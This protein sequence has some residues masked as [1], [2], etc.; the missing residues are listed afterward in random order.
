MTYKGQKRNFVID[1]DC[2]AEKL[3]SK[4]WIISD[5]LGAGGVGEV[6]ALCHKQHKCSRVI[7]IES[8]HNGTGIFH[9]EVSMLEQAH[10]YGISPI[11]YDS[12]ICSNVTVYF[13]EPQETIHTDV[14]FIV[15]DRWDGTCEDFR[16]QCCSIDKQMVMDLAMK[17]DRFTY[18]TNLYN[19]DINSNNVF[20]KLDK[21]KKNIIALTCGDWNQ[22]YNVPKNYKIDRLFTELRKA[23]GVN[24]MTPYYYQMYAEGKKKY[25]ESL[26]L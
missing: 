24:L 16:S 2:L 8:L 4:G 13:K 5:F 23:T 7:K 14:G 21:E 19:F 22:V 6:F 25:L 12:W 15:M 26:D 17:M 18:E 20:V 11:M 3:V 10:E 9:R 1:L